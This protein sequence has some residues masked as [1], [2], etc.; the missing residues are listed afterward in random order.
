MDPRSVH[1]SSSSPASTPQNPTSVPQTPV[2]LSL[3]QPFTASS[4]ALPYYMTSMSTMN[5]SPISSSS[6]PST[7]N[8]S[9]SSIPT[10]QKSNPS[11]QK[12]TP[13]APNNDTSSNPSNQQNS[14]PLPPGAKER[15]PP[16][17]TI[18][19]TDKPRPHVCNICTRSFARLEHLKRHERSH[20][21]EKPFQCP[22]CERCFAR[23]DL[24]LR[25]KQKLH[26]SFPQDPPR[27]RG[28]NKRKSVAVVSTVAGT[29]TKTNAGISKTGTAVTSGTTGSVNAAAVVAAAGGNNNNNHNHNNIHHNTPVSASFN[30]DASGNHYTSDFNSNSPINDLTPATSTPGSGASSAYIPLDYLKQNGN[31]HNYNGINAPYSSFSSQHSSSKPTNPQNDNL[32]DLSFSNLPMLMQN[33]DTSNIGNASTSLNNDLVCLLIFIC[34]WF[35][36]FGFHLN[37]Y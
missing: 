18:I 3:K 28:G 19:K 4:S 23:R 1:G 2:N 36:V 32:S 7:N 15:I 12:N 16:K 34:F 24:L 35:L 37:S 26:A 25:H 20:T 14:A 8:V 9:P 5:S 13:A 30:A 17:S 21:K 6:T 27:A 22:V 33:M 11:V 31:V 29:T 10:P